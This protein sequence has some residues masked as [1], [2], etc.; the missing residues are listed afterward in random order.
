MLDTNGWP[1]SGSWERNGSID[2]IQ[3]KRLYPADIWQ[4][5]NWDNFFNMIIFGSSLL[6]NKTRREKMNEYPSRAKP[7][8]IS[9][10]QY[11]Y[12]FSN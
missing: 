1:N 10:G 2:G 8:N 6:M 12:L 9:L 7:A 3:E 5:I 11:S 4:V